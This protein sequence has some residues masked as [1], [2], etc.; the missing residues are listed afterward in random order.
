MILVLDVFLILGLPY[1]EVQRDTAITIALLA[2]LGFTVNRE[3]SCLIPMQLITF[4]GFVID[5]FRRNV[6]APG[7]E[8][9]KSE[10][11]LQES[12]H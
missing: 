4:L 10:V 9:C 8:S 7:R 2:S 6:E 1:Q 5:F 3:N 12:N 11:Y